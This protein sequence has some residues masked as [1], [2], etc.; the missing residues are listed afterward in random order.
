MNGYKI[1]N[2]QPT[3]WIH[4]DSKCQIEKS[5]S[6][7]KINEKSDSESESFDIVL[8]AMFDIGNSGLIDSVK[9]FIPVQNKSPEIDLCSLNK[10]KNVSQ[11]QRLVTKIGR[12]KRGPGRLWT[13]MVVRFDFKNSPFFAI[14][15]IWW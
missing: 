11:N 13:Y 10:S 5:K 2:W 6:R 1:R 14:R 3:N 12:V 15:L 8:D 9:K 4:G 7:R